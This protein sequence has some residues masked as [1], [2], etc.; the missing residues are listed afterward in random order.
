MILTPKQ[1]EDLTIDIDNDLQTIIIEHSYPAL[2]IFS[3]KPIIKEGILNA[4]KV[5]I[6]EQELNI[7]GIISSNIG[8]VVKQTVLTMRE[9]TLIALTEKYER[10]VQV[11]KN[12]NS[13][14]PQ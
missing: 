8:N 9:D 7:V 13:K 6:A 12:K 4:K 5:T 14:L 11:R 1:V 3:D 2:D 10:L